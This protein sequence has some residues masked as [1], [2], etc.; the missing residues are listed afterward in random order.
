MPSPSDLVVKNG[1][2][3]RIIRSAGMPGPVSLTN[4]VTSR[5]FAAEVSMVN[6]RSFDL[7]LWLQTR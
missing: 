1:S 2:K 4:T 6:S 3:I 7:L 5:R